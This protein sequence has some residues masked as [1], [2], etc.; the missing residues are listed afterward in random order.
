MRPFAEFLVAMLP[1]DASGRRAV[2]E[3]LADWRHEA[4]EA[5]TLAAHVVTAVR[6]AAAVAVTVA[7]VACT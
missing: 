1:L 7:A 6:G 3:T 4:A 5:R 2:D